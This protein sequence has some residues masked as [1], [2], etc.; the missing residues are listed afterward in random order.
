MS[1]SRS[2]FSQAISAIG[3]PD[4]RRFASSLLLTSL[5]AQLVQTVVFWQAYELTGS[6][7]LLGLTGVARAVPHIILSMAG[8]VIADRTNRVRLIQSGQVANAIL[9]LALGVLTISGHVQLWHV[10]AV[11]VLNSAFTAVTQ[12]ARTAL[13]PHLV[14]EGN[15]VNAVALNATISQVSQIVG[16][17]LAGIAIA[18]LDTGAA[19]IINGV[20]YLAAM[21]SI[22]GIRAQVR[23]AATDASPWDSFLEG[24]RFVMQKPVILSLLALDLS[25]TIFGSYRA[26]LPIIATSLGVG[27]A[28]FGLLSAAPGV[29]AV[30]G[31][32]GILALGDMR[33]K[34][35]YTMFGVLAFCASVALLAVSPWFSIALIAAALTGVT[36]S[37]QVIPRNSAI[38]TMSPDALRGR[39][40]SFRSMLAGGGPPIGYAV[41]GAMGAALGVP[42]ALVL[43]SIAC[44][45]TVAGIGVTRHELRDPDL[46]AAV[47]ALDPPTA[48]RG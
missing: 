27:A 38:L 29:G 14:P 1:R 44:V 11:T 10:Y 41:S 35:L 40:E 47:E 18:T 7:L 43:G 20:F 39:V 4:Y 32:A 5:G 24:L 17:A 23:P 13:I 36:N 28:G 30:I 12:P 25:Q 31:A 34:G 8:G 2:G 21:A 48:T 37:I 3:Y 19:Y 26:L 15:L 22:F 33:Y 42:V 16:P 6:A 45:V 46:G 9:V